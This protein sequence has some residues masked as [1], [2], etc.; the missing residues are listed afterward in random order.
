MLLESQGDKI[1]YLKNNGNKGLSFHYIEYNDGVIVTEFDTNKTIA[2]TEQN[3]NSIKSLANNPKHFKSIQEAESYIC[4][5]I[6][7][8]K[9]EY[10][11]LPVDN[12]IDALNILKRYGDTVGVFNIGG[13]VH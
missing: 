2:R 4:S 3:I 7:I 5:N 10:I 11:M 8:D 13:E 1:L 6:G 9:D 12:S